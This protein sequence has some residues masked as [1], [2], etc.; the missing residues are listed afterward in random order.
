[1]LEAFLRL[2]KIY[3]NIFPVN[4]HYIKYEDIALDFNNT[5][6]KIYK[7]LDLEWSK[8]T[9]NFY[10]TARK[11]LDISTPSYNQ[12]TSPIYSKSINRWKNYQ[13]NF[14]DVEKYLEKWVAEFNYF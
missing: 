9:N 8:E 6:K 10:L 11:R 2:W 1:M 4:F 7:F 12:I 13:M 14:K 3:K 5:T